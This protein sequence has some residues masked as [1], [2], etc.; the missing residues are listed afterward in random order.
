MKKLTK[1]HLSKKTALFDDLTEK[2]S[3]LNA[4]IKAYNDALAD[5]WHDVETAMNDY[6]QTVQ[7][8]NEFQE[9][10][11]TDIE[12]YV[13]ERSDKWHESDQAARYEEWKGQW[14][15]VF[16]ECYIEG[17]LSLDDVEDDLSSEL[18]NRSDELPS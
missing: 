12:G 9:E 10:I 3:V 17:P 6:N 11:V 4:A 13:G 2:C 14:E 15:E 1:E 5:K 7:L 16:D 8:A 18:D